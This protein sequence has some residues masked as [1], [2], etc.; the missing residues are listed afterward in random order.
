MSSYGLLGICVPTK[1]KFMSHL[2]QSVRFILL[3]PMVEW[4]AERCWSDMSVGAWY[5]SH[6]KGPGFSRDDV[7]IQSLH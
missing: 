7:E 2:R 3:L 1:V 5:C 4:P 6:L